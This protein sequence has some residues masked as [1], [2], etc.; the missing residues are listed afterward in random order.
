ME[1]LNLNKTMLTPQITFQ[2]NGVLLLKG[3]ST[4]EDVNA[5]YQPVI[6][7]ITAFRI[8]KPASINFVMEVDYLNT[9]STHKMVQILSLLNDFRKDGIPVTFTWRYDEEDEDMLDL[10]TDLKLT[11]KSE[12]EFIAIKKD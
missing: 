10:G 8:T 9:S 2:S 7:W 1:N 6:D 11:S 5:F 12:M 4:P 3:V